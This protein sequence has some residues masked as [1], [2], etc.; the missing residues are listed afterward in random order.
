MRT[1]RW[2]L[3]VVGAA[4]GDAHARIAVVN[5]A[6]SKIAS[7]LHWA[8]TARQCGGRRLQP[9]RAFTVLDGLLGRTAWRAAGW[10]MPVLRC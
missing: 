4:D 1:Q 10:F 7:D 2:T 8:W 5:T 9:R 6:L 3:V